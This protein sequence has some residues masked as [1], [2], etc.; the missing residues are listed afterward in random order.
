M[1]TAIT[2]AD[3]AGFDAD[4]EY[5]SF[6]GWVQNESG[7]WVEPPQPEGGDAAGAG[8]GGDQGAGAGAGDQGAGGS[9]AGSGGQPPL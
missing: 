7:E 8:A 4:A 1:T 2:A 3:T 6:D 9:G 5:E